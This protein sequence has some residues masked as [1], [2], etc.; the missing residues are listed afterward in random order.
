MS[1]SDNDFDDDDD[2][3][4]QALVAGKTKIVDSSVVIQ[5]T[6]KSNPVKE[7]S[8]VANT[9]ENNR[10]GIKSIELAELQ[11]K[12]YRADGEIAILRA[13]LDQ[14]NN[15]K[16]DEIGQLKKNN[17]ELKKQHD[18][19]IETLKYTVHKL[20]D[21]KKF[22][23][24]ELKSFS[25]SKKRKTIK[26]PIINDEPLT[27]NL[28]HNRDLE[29]VLNLSFSSE[30]DPHIS[31]IIK[32]QNDSSLFTDFIWSYS[33]NGAKRTS[34]EYLSKT[35]VNEDI[36]IND[37]KLLKKMP[38]SNS[39]FEYLM[40]KKDS[41]LDILIKDFCLLMV[42]LIKILLQREKILCVPFLLSLIHCSI[43]FRPA[44]ISKCL[45]KNLLSSICE[46]AEKYLYLL[47]SNLNQDEL[48][49]NNDVPVQV[50]ILEKLTLICCMDI[51]EK[52]V[53]ISTIYDAE[54]IKEIWNDKYISIDLISSGLP[55]NS[56]RFK[57]SAQI[58]IIHNIVEMLI[59][60]I[61]EDTFAFNENSKIPKE[62]IF[63]SLLKI[64]LIELPI[65]KE[66][67][68]YGLN[69][70]IGNNYDS[71]T[72]EHIIPLKENILNNPIISI[73]EPVPSGLLENIDDNEQ[74]KFELL[75]KHENHLLHLR[76]KVTNL[77][78]SYVVIKQ[79]TDFLQSKEN[80]KAIIRIIGFEQIYVMR[81]P[82]SKFVHLRVQIISNFI[83]ILDYLLKS[84]KNI[85]DW[86]YP[87]T[88]SEVFVV[89]LRI[90]FGSDSLSMKGNH[91]LTK[92]REKGFTTEVV[93]NGWCEKRAR[94]LNLIDNPNAK[95]DPKLQAD[96]ESE[97][98]N[99][100][101]FPYHPETIELSRE[102]LNNFVDHEEADNL[103]FNMNYEEPSN[104]DEMDLVE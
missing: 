34:L 14:L 29:T 101:E 33:I 104:F 70:I 24:E 58:N 31:L 75:S 30:D 100:L 62:T 5:K 91:M 87:E 11:T 37:L 84:T 64:F 82:R 93:F 52:L 41:R 55:E 12:L 99:G 63:N 53:S 1:S 66:F 92:I 86:M 85:N 96:I 90:A 23:N 43:S 28:S 44:A 61:S 19:Q 4:L 79:S 35:F 51:I 49:N 25:S 48:A 27:P 73:P 65:K 36:N 103:Y 10:S 26:S 42:E 6:D 2:I 94:Q 38:I 20:E 39:I 3:L 81:S 21:E 76:M 15:Q 59:T 68:F 45:I 69:R 60:S 17:I 77:L 47:D 7:T 40:L 97:F 98:A 57:N 71:S 46:I 80:I 16:Q 72:L 32:I 13:Q 56:E 9:E 78:E 89:L 74:L 54:F 95:I 67:M 22:L 83:K 8:T 102:I 88:M 50:I 18:D